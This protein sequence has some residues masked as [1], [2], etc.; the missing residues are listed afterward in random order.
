M[1]FTIDP[2][3]MHL[4]VN[5]YGSATGIGWTTDL[6]IVDSVELPSNEP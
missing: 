6:D 4:I 5:F 3:G 1:L 2:R